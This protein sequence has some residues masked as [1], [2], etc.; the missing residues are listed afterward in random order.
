MARSRSTS[1]IVRWVVNATGLLLI[2][3]LA[4]VALWPS[5]VDALPK[6]LRWFGQPGSTATMAIVVAVVV[7]VCVLTFGSDGSTRHRPAASAHLGRKQCQRVPEGSRVLPSASRIHL[8]WARRSTRSP[9]R[10]RYRP[11]CV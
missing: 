10:R 1:P 4:A 9:R 6:S 7:A 5:I 11:C 8:R 3:Y 2:G